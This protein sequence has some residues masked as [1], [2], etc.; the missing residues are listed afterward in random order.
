MTEILQPKTTEAPK[1]PLIRLCPWPE[2]RSFALFLSH[3]VDQIHDRELFRV[4]ADANHIRRRLMQGET[5]DTRLAGIRLARSLFW[6]KPAPKDFATLLEME[7]RHGFRSTFFLLHDKYWA[8]HGG[9]YS[10]QCPEIQNIARM[11]LAAGGELG[12]HGGYYRFNDAVRYH[13]SLE[14]VESS[15][16]VRPCGIR[17]HL[18]RF[19]YPETW[20]A[21]AAAEFAYDASYG[22]P[23]E[24]GPRGGW[25]FPFETCDVSKGELLNL[26]ALPITVMDA[27]LFRHL[28]LEGEAALEKAWR[29]VEGVIGVGG[30]VS[31]LWHNNYFNEPE[32][33]DWQMVYEELLNRLAPLKP[34]CATGA[35]IN[36]WWRA[37]AA[38]NVQT[39]PVAGE[40]TRVEIHSPQ[41]IKDLALEIRSTNEMRTSLPNVR[42]EPVEGGTR[43]HFP[44]LS[45]GK[46][47][48]LE[49]ATSH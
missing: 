21:Q 18:L 19:S 25:P 29:A 30:M 39:H 13:E 32:Y 14:A 44:R 31:L 7:E 24:L 2:G 48:T 10:L 11:I 6:P 20:R 15:F 42:L 9:R 1:A 49:V 40:K 22:L 5:G 4:L 28:R 17:N 45:A 23:G 26:M 43:I 46:T 36:G 35:E 41:E 34:W 12:V 27:T 37:K 38:V 3:D 8:R 47:V 33:W 16:G